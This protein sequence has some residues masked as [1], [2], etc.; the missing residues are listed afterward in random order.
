[1]GK[2]TLRL[3]KRK[4]AAKLRPATIDKAR[5]EAMADIARRRQA[6]ENIFLDKASALLTQHWSKSDWTARAA[7]LKTADWLIRVAGKPA[8]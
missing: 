2:K 6:G 4:P 5:E 7:L 8:T 3:P 1:M